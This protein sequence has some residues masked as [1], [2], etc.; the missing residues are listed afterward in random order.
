[1]K[2]LFILLGL[3]L[4]TG[5]MSFS[6]RPL[7]PLRNAIAQQMPKVSLEKEFAVSFGRGFFDLLD[8]V[9]LNEADLSKIDH[10]Q[11]A[12]YKVYPDGIKIDFDTLDFE[13]VMLA[14]DSSLHWETIIRVREEDE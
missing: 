13:A 10:V 12:V 5:C 2:N 11:L 4:L 8:I 9:T 6:D 14:K 7:R 3:V 1:M